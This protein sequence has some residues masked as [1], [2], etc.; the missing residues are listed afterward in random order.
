RPSEERDP[1]LGAC[2]TP[3]QNCTA[4]IVNAIGEAKQEICVQAYSFTSAPIA[5]ALVR[6]HKNGVRVLVL[7]D[8]SQVKEKRSRVWMLKDAGIDVWVDVLP[9]IAH[10]KVMIIDQQMVLTG[11]FNWTNAA[12]YRNAENVVFIKEPQIVRYYKENWLKRHELAV[13]NLL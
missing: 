4:L 12:E 2:F 3:G 8:K 7:V 1:V 11:S 5:E 13:Q 6:A 9:G 10:N